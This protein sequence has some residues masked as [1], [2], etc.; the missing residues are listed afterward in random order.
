MAGI[1]I[2]GT[3][4]LYKNPKPHVRSVHAY[5]PSVA[6]LG[7][8]DMVA[9]AVLG[10]A[11]EA[12]D[13]HAHVFRSA[14]AGET[15]THHGPIYPGVQ[16]RLV[17][18]SCR[19]TPL[20]GDSLAA[21][22]IRHDRTDYADEGLTNPDTLGFVPTELTLM[23]SDDRGV[24]WTGPVPMNP[25]LEGPSFEM[26][27]PI[28]VLRNGRWL[29]PTSTWPG[30]DGHCPNGIKMVTLVSE[31]Q[32][33]TWPFHYDVMQRPEGRVFFWESKIVEL[34]DGRLLAVAWTY[35]EEAGKDEPNHYALSTDSGATWTAPM[36]MG[37]QGQTLTPLVLGDGRVLVVY[38]RMDTP[39]LWATVARLDGDALVNEGDTPIW[40]A[41]ADGLTATTDNMAH[42]FN[43]LRFGAPCL[44]R[45]D[46]GTAYLAFW[47]YED[48]VSVIRWYKLRV[49]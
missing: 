13:C 3:G 44:T 18:D 45:M 47:C 29:L 1:D 37:I 16:D 7:G 23:R 24:T 32:G 21:F 8:G 34:T 31:D 33:A 15:W 9:T 40:G 48:C 22:L 46:N 36:S 39:G 6:D 42:N 28:T 4:V 2:L 17:S 25:A 11:F 14:D 12:A 19:L 26:C 49:G 38:R 5:F 35:D 20:S 30:W 43:V 41:Q 27:S 10:Q